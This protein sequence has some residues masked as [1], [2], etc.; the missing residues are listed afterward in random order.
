[1]KK[2]LLAVITTALAAALCCFGL[3]G[4]DTSNQARFVTGGESGTYYAYGTVLAQYA[5]NNTDVTINAL[6]SE[7]SKTNVDSLASADAELAFCQLDVANYSY[8]GANLFQGMSYDGFSIVAALYP[9][10]VQIVT[11]N[12]DIKSVAD[13]KGK[14]ISVGAAN[15]GVYFNAVDILAAYDLTMDDVNPVYQNFAD[16]TDSLK[17]NKIDAAFVTAGAPTTSITDLSTTNPAYLVSLD[18]EHIAKLQESCPYYEEAIIEGGTYSTMT[19]DTTT[20]SVLSIILADDSLDDEI[21]YQFTKSI[22]EGAEAQPDAHAKYSELN[23]E[24]A[25]S[26]T[27]IPYAKGA[28]KYYAEVGIEVPTK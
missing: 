27:S 2:K 12:P 14:T 28:A 18:D 11:C 3:A 22:F 20:V 4:C 7:G 15:S 23:L 24:T 17:N 10:Q 5:T 19:E 13:L 26:V 16:S 25:T 8:T 9:E 1:M 21:V 6:A